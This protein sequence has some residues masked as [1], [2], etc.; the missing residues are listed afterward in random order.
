M[1]KELSE[2]S[3]EELWRLFPIILTEHDPRWRDWYEEEAAR[4]RAVLPVDE[5]AR[6]S[7][8]GSTAVAGIWAKPTVDILLEARGGFEGVKKRAFG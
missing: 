5:A 6:I 4:L 2:M 1:S 7:H 8:I 3:L